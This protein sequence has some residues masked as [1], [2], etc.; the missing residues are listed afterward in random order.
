MAAQVPAGDPAGATRLGLSVSANGAP[1]STTYGPSSPDG[2]VSGGRGGASVDATFYPWTPLV[3]D[4][5]PRS[6]QPFLQRTSFLELSGNGEYTRE[7]YS[8]AAQG[9]TYTQDY[10]YASV[11]TRYFFTPTVAILAGA[12]VDYVHDVRAPATALGRTRNLWEP[13]GT[14]G[15]DVRSGDASLTLQW[16]V[17]GASESVNGAPVNPPPGVYWPRLTLGGRAVVDRR[18]DLTG[19]VGL[20]PD[21]ATA[22]AGLGVYPTQDLGLTLFAQYDHGQIYLDSVADYDRVQGGPGVTYWVSPRVE[23]GLSYTPQWIRSPGDDT[24]WNHQVTLG[25]IGRLP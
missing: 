15:L 8:L 17:T 22:R 19:D 24:T 12:G 13:A 11:S 4:A 3:D 2:E 14:V 16:E 10:A 5:S 7:S 6:L 20:L 21:G 23:L 9:G 1:E 18:F 25:V